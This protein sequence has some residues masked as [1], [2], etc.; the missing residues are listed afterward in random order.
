MG[1]SE[2]IKILRNIVSYVIQSCDIKGMGYE[3]TLTPKIEFSLCCI[4]FRGN[5]SCKKSS[6]SYGEL[7]QMY[8]TELNF[9][10]SSCRF[11]KSGFVQWVCICICLCIEIF[12]MD[13]TTFVSATQ[14]FFFFLSLWQSSFFY[15]CIFRQVQC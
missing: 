7:N 4:I 5:V 3:G 6:F 1:F 2:G 10:H 14:N 12:T 11:V 9:V 8:G 13:Q 15:F